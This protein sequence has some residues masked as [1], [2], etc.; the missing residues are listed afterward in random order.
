[1]SITLNHIGLVV[2]DASESAKLLGVLGFQQVTRPEP[3][4]IQKVKA[5]FL[6]GTEGK[7]PHIEL[8]E[9]RDQDSP[10]AN[11]LGKRGGGLHHMCFEVDDIDEA[12]RELKQ[13]GFKL[14]S[15]PVA[16]IG[17]DRSFELEQTRIAFFMLPNKLLIELL[18]KGKEAGG[19]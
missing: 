18:Q 4:P 14:V 9:P 8:L 5:C 17:Y 1:M 19:E 2:K 3:D 12:T 6:A 13:K 11:F 7:G 15:S 16:C 10:V